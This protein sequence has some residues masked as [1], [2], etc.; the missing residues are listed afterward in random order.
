MYKEYKIVDPRL[1]VS[2]A[3]EEEVSFSG[4]DSTNHWLIPSFLSA[5]QQ[6]W[7]ENRQMR[8]WLNI[9]DY[10]SHILAAFQKQK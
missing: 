4:E 8:P 1:S 3:R 10:T 9:Y 6:I 7:I 5:G 2:F